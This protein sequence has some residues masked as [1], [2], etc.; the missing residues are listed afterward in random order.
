MFSLLYS[1]NVSFHETLLKGCPWTRVQ[2]MV[3]I[4]GSSPIAPGL[5]VDYYLETHREQRMIYEAVLRGDPA[6]VR[7]AVEYHIL[8]TK[9]NLIHYMELL[10]GGNQK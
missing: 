1:I 10:N 3:G 4:L 6:E 5:L 8:R 2:K 9:N 7:L